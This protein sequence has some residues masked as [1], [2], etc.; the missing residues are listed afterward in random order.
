MDIQ[1][2]S[3]KRDRLVSIVTPVFNET[4]NLPEYERQLT[5]FMDRYRGQY[6]F[7]LVFTDNASTDH[8]FAY[9]RDWAERDFRV[10]A[11][12]L[13]RNY[14]YQRSI[15]TGYSLARG[16]AAIELDADLQEPLEVIDQFLSAWDQGHKVVYG[17][18]AKRAEG[19][20]MIFL[21]R[22]YYRVL[23]ALCEYDLP[24]DAGDF[25]L[26]DREVLNHL[27]ATY[28]P[29]IYIRGVI[30]GLGFKRLGIPYERLA[31]HRGVTKFAPRKL[32]ELA[33]DGIVGQSVIPLRL[34]S[35]F[36]LLIAS[37]T[38]LMSL[39]YV[40][41]KLTVGIPAPLGF[42]TLVVIILLSTSLNAIFLGIL[43][44]Y[45]ARIYQ[46]ARRQPMSVVEEATPDRNV[47]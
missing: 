39:I 31:R 24:A 38:F 26:I 41:L 2:E 45:V 47:L 7:E 22:V 11:F 25:M 13:S 3:A 19:A 18:R 29:Q 44:E 34:A 28:D 10:R 46:L 20:F 8:S 21:R 33:M 16:D 14:G 5:A 1:P 37:A 23:R 42:T 36:G 27:K 6:R 32:A 17:I 12:R 4:E 30:F 35:G 43:G 40:V 9:L 15:F